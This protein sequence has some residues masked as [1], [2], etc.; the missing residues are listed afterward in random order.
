MDLDP[1][2]LS[3]DDDFAPMPARQGP[4]KVRAASFR[5][6]QS[7][8]KK[9][10][11]KSMESSMSD[12]QYRNLFGSDSSD[13]EEDNNSDEEEDVPLRDSK[14]LKYMSSDDV[15]QA[16]GNAHKSLVTLLS[17][18]ETLLKEISS[19]KAKAA[20]AKADNAQKA[21]VIAKLTKEV[22][23]LKK[24]CK[25]VTDERDKARKEAKKAIA[26]LE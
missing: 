8:I 6:P 18:S 15:M 22:A 17:S 9:P 12:E 2:E 5:R 10:S 3:D 23:D 13:V 25:K 21:G 7:R 4:T 1:I 11:L 26:P 19:E 24:Q 20:S 14:R 16:A